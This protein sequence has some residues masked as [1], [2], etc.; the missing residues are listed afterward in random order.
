MSDKIPTFEWNSEESGKK[1]FHIFKAALQAHLATRQCQF[2]LDENAIQ[3]NTPLD[4][5][6][7][8]NG[9][10]DLREWRKLQKTF[11][12]EQKKFYGLFDMAIGILQSMLVYPSKARND[13]DIALCQRPADIPQEQWTPNQQ[14][15]AAMEKLRASYAPRNKTDT[16]TLRRQL[17]ELSDDIEGGFHEYANQFVRIYTELIKSEVPNIVGETKLREWVK[18]GFKNDQVINHLAATI[19]HHDVA[20]QPTF[21]QIFAH[22]GTKWSY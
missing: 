19:C 2:V 16:T 5:G 17:Q 11:W 4:P 22:K 3:I 9:A 15:Q 12:V 7:E 18:A 1:E 14:F 21:E 20:A 8:P 10:A 13:I 6:P